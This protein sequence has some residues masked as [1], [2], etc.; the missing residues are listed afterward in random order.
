MSQ[1]LEETMQILEEIPGINHGMMNG[2]IVQQPPE[3]RLMFLGGGGIG[4]KDHTAYIPLP[5]VVYHIELPRNGTG[6]ASVQC[7][8]GRP[9]PIE[10][11]EDMLY[12]MP[13]PN[14]YGRWNTIGHCSS[15]SIIQ[16]DAPIEQLV[17]WILNACWESSWRYFYF[18][19]S[20]SSD[21][22]PHSIPE[23]WVGPR[24]GALRWLGIDDLA[25]IVGRGDLTGLYKKWE[26][27]SLEEATQMPWGRPRCGTLREFIE[28]KRAS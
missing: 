22:S 2:Y 25:G 21:G 6:G 5:Y 19:D 7:L 15:M 16:Q 24:N 14:N 9:E 13:L 8:F 28:Y 4:G 17:G 3:H 1:S 23:E 12:F 26:S 18:P 11:D 20:Y 27:L 10:T